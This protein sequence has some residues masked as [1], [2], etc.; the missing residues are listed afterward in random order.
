MQDEMVPNCYLNACSFFLL[1]TN[2]SMDPSGVG[3]D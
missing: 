2:M 3:L 1:L